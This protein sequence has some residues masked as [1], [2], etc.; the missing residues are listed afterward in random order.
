MPPAYQDDPFSARIASLAA[1]LKARMPS[2]KLTELVRSVKDEGERMYRLLTHWG[3]ERLAAI[4]W[5]N[6]LDGLSAALTSFLPRAKIRCDEHTRLSGW[7][8]NA[9]G[10]QAIRN[11]TR[12]LYE[13][14]QHLAE[15][16]AKAKQDF[17][18][19]KSIRLPG[20]E[21]VDG[22]P[23]L[24]NLALAEGRLKL[25]GLKYAEI[26]LLI[27]DQHQAVPSESRA[28]RDHQERIRKRIQ[29]VRLRL[30]DEERTRAKGRRLLQDLAT[31][32]SK[33]RKN[34]K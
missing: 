29:S 33:I 17:E 11:N 26:A 5:V 4:A 28:L 21:P 18:Y 7:S 16:A 32:R 20:L 27:P 23:S 8:G 10:Y 19:D 25:A 31:K 9:P 12:A 2:A 6:S 3:P 30:I 15:L 24:E 14:A 13:S 22:R 34:G 1:S